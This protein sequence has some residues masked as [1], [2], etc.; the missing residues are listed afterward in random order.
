VGSN[1]TPSAMPSDLTKK[2]V[3]FYCAHDAAHLESGD[4]RCQH[5]AVPPTLMF[6]PA[7]R[8]DAGL[9]T[10]RW[11][12]WSGKNAAR[13]LIRAFILALGRADDPSSVKTFP[14]GAFLWARSRCISWDVAATGARPE[15][16]AGISHGLILESGMACCCYL[17]ERRRRGFLRIARARLRAAIAFRLP[18]RGRGCSVRRGQAYDAA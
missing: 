12:K 8:A 14:V 2:F 13:S 9:P 18:L 5:H 15:R 16:R 3:I 7:R 10:M 1:P 17:A 11:V 4:G 6:L